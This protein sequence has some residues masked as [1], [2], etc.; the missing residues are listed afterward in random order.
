M[1]TAM[2]QKGMQTPGA[3]KQG[4]QPRMQQQGMQQPGMQQPMMKG[5]STGIVGRVG[6]PII[7]G[8]G[9]SGGAGAGTA[10]TST[11]PGG[12][13]PQTSSFPGGTGAKGSSPVRE[14]SSFPGGGGRDSSTSRFPIA[15]MQGGKGQLTQGRGRDSSTSKTVGGGKGGG[16]KGGG[17]GGNPNNIPIAPF[18]SGGGSSGPGTTSTLAAEQ[19]DEHDHDAVANW[20]NSG[21]D[22]STQHLSPP[23]HQPMTL[24]QTA[25]QLA[26]PPGGNNAEALQG[27]TET[28]DPLPVPS[29]REQRRY[30]HRTVTTRGVEREC[31]LK[32]GEIYFSQS[33]CRSVFQHGQGNIQGLMGD[34]RDAKRLGKGPSDVLAGPHTIR[35]VELFGK[36]YTLDH[37]R[38]AAV[39]R[40]RPAET[41]ADGS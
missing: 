27:T 36:I 24:Q 35:V 7:M 28:E 14:A 6:L 23:W 30:K 39:K 11:F 2:Q 15:G 9:A 16:G 8:G 20:Q 4:V 26:P 40:G 10:Q 37:R 38:L 19:H 17:G 21:A 25:R 18:S 12:A 13:P 33:N 5:S 31:T 32:V 22:M 1:L 3:G 34:L 29:R 41:E